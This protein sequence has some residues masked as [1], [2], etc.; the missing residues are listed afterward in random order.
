VRDALW[1]RAARA[2]T[3]T[4]LGAA[5]DD[6]WI[7]TARAARLLSLRHGLETLPLALVAA[8]ERLPTV[9]LHRGR[10]VTALERAGPDTVRITTA[11]GAA[12]VANAVVAA[13]P[14]ATLASLLRAP[15]DTMAAGA[16]QGLVGS[17]DVAVVNV[18]YRGGSGVRL[19][20]RAFGYLVP[21]WEPA[22]VLG[23]VF[24]SDAFPEQNRHGP[25]R[26]VAGG[27]ALNHTARRRVRCTQAC[28]RR[29]ADGHAGGTPVPRTVRRPR[30]GGDG[31]TRGGGAACAGPGT[32][33]SRG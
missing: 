19:P 11:D 4:P 1:P 33:S 14:S 15:A 12:V 9:T 10:A 3:P 27:I 23:V 22:D 18:A 7:A 16:L 6:P 30:H 5:A 32:W 21:S 26:T 31:D 28:G 8:L 13:V 25:T 24:D 2:P 29:A 17:T 20:W